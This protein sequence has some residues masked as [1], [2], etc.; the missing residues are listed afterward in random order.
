MNTPF[1]INVDYAKLAPVKLR[2]RL[3]CV[4]PPCGNVSF[5]CPDLRCVQLT[6]MLCCQARAAPVTARPPDGAT[7]API[8]HTDARA[9]RGTSSAVASA[10]VG[11]RRAR[12]RGSCLSS[13]FKDPAKQNGRLDKRDSFYD[14]RPFVQKTSEM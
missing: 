1:K 9:S 3:C 7:R 2:L 8:S 12:L 14:R 5:V 10:S 6:M 13:P 11:R 4:P